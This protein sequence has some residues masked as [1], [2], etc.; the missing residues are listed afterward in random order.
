MN[1]EMLSREELIKIIHGIDQESL[2]A[3]SIEELR[4][5]LRVQLRDTEISKKL[6]SINQVSRSSAPYSS[7]TTDSAMKS[8]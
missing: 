1:H 6:D 2:Q 3:L 4:S 8:S 7:G 5:L